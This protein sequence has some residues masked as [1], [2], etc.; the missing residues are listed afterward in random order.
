MEETMAGLYLREISKG[1][2]IGI[3]GVGGGNNP[4]ENSHIFGSGMLVGNFFLPLKGS[5]MGVA[6]TDSTP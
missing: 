1:L 2:V 4:G 6:L 3:Q 5:K